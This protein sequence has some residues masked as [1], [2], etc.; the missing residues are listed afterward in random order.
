M[1]N[2]FEIFGKIPIEWYRTPYNSH[3][4]KKIGIFIRQSW[5]DLRCHNNVSS[6]QWIKEIGFSQLSM[7]KW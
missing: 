2:L 4:Y 6:E 7:N 1:C 5:Q 3:K